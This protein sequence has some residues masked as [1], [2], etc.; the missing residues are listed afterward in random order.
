MSQNNN[1][2][3]VFEQDG[4]VYCVICHTMP[5]KDRAR[6]TAKAI[7][8]MA[9]IPRARMRV[10]TREEFGVMPFGEPKEE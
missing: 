8:E 1:D 7:R 5:T 4:K 9:K 6:E 2:C 3:T 10:V